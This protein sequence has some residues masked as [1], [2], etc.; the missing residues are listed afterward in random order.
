MRI[1]KKQK[2][3]EEEERLIESQK[4]GVVKNHSEGIRTQIISN[5]E[6]KK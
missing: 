3:V 4:K 1:I 6:K 5:E 2:E